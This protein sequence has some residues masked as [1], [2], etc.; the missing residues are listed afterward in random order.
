VREHTEFLEPNRMHV[1]VH[2]I[3]RY[4]GDVPD[5]AGAIRCVLKK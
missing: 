3:P 4:K 1:P 5:P 2:L